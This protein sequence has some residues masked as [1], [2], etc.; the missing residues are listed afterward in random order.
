VV[1]QGKGQSTGELEQRADTAMY[2]AKQA[3]RNRIVFFEPSMLEN[4][5]RRTGL[6]ADLREALPL[7]AIVP[8][9]HAQ[10]DVRGRVLGAEVLLRWS[11]PQRGWVSPMEFIP[12]AEET[13]LIM[14]LGALA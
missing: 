10:V 3:G 12:L 5:A 11:H 4:L 1:F 9:L 8:F 13:G 2:Q 14:P 6:E 7:G